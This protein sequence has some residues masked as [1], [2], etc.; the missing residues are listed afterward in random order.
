MRRVFLLLISFLDVETSFWM[1]LDQKMDI[2]FK[3][4][5]KSTTPLNF[6]LIMYPPRKLIMYPPKPDF[7]TMYPLNITGYTFYPLL[8]PNN[9]TF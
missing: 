2:I 9:D 4:L 3:F 1:S 5:E 8:P 7:K 6:F